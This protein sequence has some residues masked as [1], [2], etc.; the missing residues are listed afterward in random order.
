MLLA[1]LLRQPSVVASMLPAVAP[2]AMS[3]ER[4]PLFRAP[5]PR[6]AAT[7]TSL[8][9]KAEDPAAPAVVAEPAAPA[10]A[11]PAAPGAALAAADSG[12]AG[13]AEAAAALDMLA[14]GEDSEGSA[15]E[16]PR[17]AVQAA[18]LVSP[19]GAAPMEVEATPAAPG[20]APAA[21]PPPAAAA[22]APAAPA[23]AGDVHS[24]VP[25]PIIRA[26][27]AA[28]QLLYHQPRPASC[29]PLFKQAPAGSS[30]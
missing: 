23:E 25:T 16:G 18:A 13:T 14:G 8:K 6:G 20:S 15:A 9:R 19:A 26:F 12:S 4:P 1:G 30:R 7:L 29:P 10:T 2:A 22:A 24:Q 11:A 28:D 17:Q 27:A 3:A 21:L 5:A